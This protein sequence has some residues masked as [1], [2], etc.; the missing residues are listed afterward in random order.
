MMRHFILVAFTLIATSG[1]SQDL[2]EELLLDDEK[3][4]HYTSA[5]FKDTRIVNLQSN[6]TPSAGV[7][8]FVIMHR[9]GTVSYTHLTLPTKA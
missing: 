9:F 2:I 3:D 1:F 5:T 6:E 8:H 4:T 7:L